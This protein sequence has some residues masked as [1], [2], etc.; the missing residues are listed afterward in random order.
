MPNHLHVLVE[1]AP[2]T[3]LGAIQQ[4]WKG[5]SSRKINQ[6]LSRHGPI[7]QK[8]AFD[9]IVR[10]ATRLNDFRRYIAGNPRNAKLREGDY[11]LGFGCERIDPERLLEKCSRDFSP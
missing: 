4:R 3:T 2:D 8:E 5:S 1:P 10:N 11:I 7:W 6:L 9:H